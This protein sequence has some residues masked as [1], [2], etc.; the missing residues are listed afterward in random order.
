[1]ICR[2]PQHLAD[3]LGL[4]MVRMAGTWYGCRNKP[5]YVAGLWNLVGAGVEVMFLWHDVLWIGEDK[6]S[7]HC[8]QKRGKDNG[9]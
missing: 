1:M 8:P 2:T 7:L 5:R 9:S 3:F 4:Y 6:D